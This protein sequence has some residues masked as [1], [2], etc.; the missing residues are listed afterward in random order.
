MLRKHIEGRE[1]KWHNR[2][3]NRHARPFEW[4]IEHLGLKNGSDPKVALGRYADDAIANS[5][6]FFK[7]DPNSDF[8]FDGYNLSFPSPVRSAHPVNNTVRARFFGAE[9]PLA[10]IVLPQWNAQPHSHLGLCR[11]LQRFG[12]AALRM[13]LP[14]H[15]DRR[16]DHLERAEYLV[17][18]NIGQTIASNRQAVL[19]VRRA[20]DWL[21]TRGYT[22]LGVLGTSIGSCI[23]FMAMAH[24][25]RLEYNAYIHVSSL[26]ADVVWNG[27]STSHIRRSLESTVNLEELRRFWAP[28]SPYPFIHRLTGSRCPLLFLTGKYDL[29]FPFE[30]SQLAFTEF[31]RFDVK[32]ERVILPCGHYTMAMFPFR[33]IVGFQVVKFYRRYRN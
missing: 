28:I 11:I 25:P 17:G 19:E 3:T 31:D 30:L 24:D 8:T 10:V 29:S 13:S 16:P 14:Y 26:F 5:E 1:R 32:H 22:R 33:E 18:P 2:D 27:L 20:A 23:G 15:D 4:G 9:G 12:V 21:E 6:Q 7:P